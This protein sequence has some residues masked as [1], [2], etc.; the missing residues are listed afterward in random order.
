[1][2]ASIYY[3]QVLLCRYLLDQGGFTR[4][5]FSLSVGSTVLQY[6]ILTLITYCQGFSKKG[7]NGVH[8]VRPAHLKQTP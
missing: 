8:K 5:L 4:E 7:K 3:F 6:F 2:G 1:M